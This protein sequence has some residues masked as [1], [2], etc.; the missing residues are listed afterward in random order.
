[1][2]VVLGVV[3]VWLV[4]GDL[5]M[6]LRLFRKRFYDVMLVA[7][8]RDTASNCLSFLVLEA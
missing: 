2:V 4:N 1:V 6:D 8:G 7:S 3:W 5:Q